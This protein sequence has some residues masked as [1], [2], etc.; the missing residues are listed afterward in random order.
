MSKF[1]TVCG[2]IAFVLFFLMLGAVGAIEQDIVPPFPRNGPRVRAYGP[3]GP[4]LQPGRRVR[5]YRTGKEEA[6]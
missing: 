3:V 2:V 4:V 6:A 1:K 5:L